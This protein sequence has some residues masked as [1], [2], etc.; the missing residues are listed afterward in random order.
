MCIYLV[1]DSF[2]GKIRSPAYE[3]FVK[4]MILK[5]PKKTKIGRNDKC[6]CGSG[7]KSKFCCGKN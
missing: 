5:L 7:K 1:L 4:N 6:L 2:Q 3:K